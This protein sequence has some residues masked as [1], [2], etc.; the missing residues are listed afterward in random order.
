MNPNV[1]GNL[2]KEFNTK[3]L[4]TP[5][6]SWGSYAIACDILGIDTYHGVDVIPNVV[7]T[8]SEKFP[9]YNDES[10]WEINNSNCYQTDGSGNYLTDINGEYI[11]ENEM[12]Y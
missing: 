12:F 6:L 1:V 8:L 5:V 7:N 11:Y 2:L 4:F 10:S 3:K 9:K